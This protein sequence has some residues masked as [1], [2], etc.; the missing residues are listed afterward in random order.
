MR[1][2]LLPRQAPT[3]LRDLPSCSVER[4][5]RRGG[6][7]IL[8]FRGERSGS[9][10]QFPRQWVILADELIYCANGNQAA[11]EFVEA[12][13]SLGGIGMRVAV[14]FGTRPE[15]IKMAPVVRALQDNSFFDCQVWSTGQHREM[16]DQVLSL[17]SLRADVDLGLM[18]PGQTLNG[19][20]AAAVSGVD[21]MLEAQA[22]DI[23]L[24]H[25]D[26]STAAAAATAAFH[27]RIPVAHVE[28]GLRSGHL[29]QPWPE[30]F[31][32]R[33]VDMVS[34]LLFA[35]TAGAQN[36][37]VAEGVDPSR[38][39]V[40][41]NTVI[42]ALMA[43]V[44]RMNSDPSV[45]ARMDE[46]FGF[47]SAEKRLVLVTGH[48]RESFGGG[49]ENI[50]RALGRLGANPDVEI[51]YPVHLN[52]NVMEPVH[53]L[54][55]GS[56]R[57]HLVEPADYEAFVYLMDRCDVILTDSGGV[58]EEAPS[59]GKPVLVMRDVTERPEAIDAGVSRLVGTDPDRIV[60]GVNEALERGMQ[61]GITNP[62]G[63]GQ[64]S[65]R[66]VQEL[67]NAADDL[68]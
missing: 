54:L 12:V 62:Y 11:L 1:P 55:G 27:R 64:A 29:D 45:R 32:R 34:R 18:T 49:F 52:P 36:N 14:V 4:E 44:A 5:C 9:R 65:R 43:M 13:P 38:V 58:Q 53:R 30:E 3:Q 7:E 24:V 57:V 41:G 39:F 17:F 60:A 23:V 59:L 33:L 48:R 10:T 67:L 2:S 56:D 26:T 37:V 28:A 6:N 25:G 66:I 20:F 50:C 46:R 42:D 63:D 51:I 40:T 16:L 19:L 35:P 8:D 22:P 15:A 68:R 31:N 47:L 21:R 61:R